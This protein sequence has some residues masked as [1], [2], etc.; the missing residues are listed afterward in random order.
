MRMPSKYD[1]EK[2]HGQTT[3]VTGASRGLGPADS[4][5][6]SFASQGMIAAAPIKIPIP[7]YVVFASRVS[8]QCQYRNHG[9]IGR[10]HK[11]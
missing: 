11:Q 9:Y 8:Q 3:I 4:L 5:R 7:R 10:K 6:F 1:R 2:L